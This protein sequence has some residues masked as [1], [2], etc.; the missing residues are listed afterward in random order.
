MHYSPLSYL[1]SFFVKQPS[2]E[3]SPSAPPKTD[4][5]FKYFKDLVELIPQKILI[6]SI[7]EQ[8]IGKTT[9]LNKLFK[10][11]FG[12][13]EMT[14][15]IGS[16]IKY[17]DKI[18][19]ENKI[20]I[21]FKGFDNAEI[22]HKIENIIFSLSFAICDV[23]F[24]HIPHQKLDSKY[25]ERFSYKYWLT[26]MSLKILQKAPPKIILF[27]RDPMIN[28]HLE[29]LEIDENMNESVIKFQRLVNENLKAI[30]ERYSVFLNI[31]GNSPSIQKIKDHLIYQDFEIIKF[32]P[33]YFN[34]LDQEYC[35]RE[36]KTF[37]KFKYEQILEYLKQIFDNVASEKN[38][39]E[40]QNQ[41]DLVSSKNDIEEYFKPVIANSIFENWIKEFS[42]RNKKKPKFYYYCQ[43][44]ERNYQYSFTNFDELVINLE[45]LVQIY[46][47]FHQEGLNAK[48]VLYSNPKSIES[49]KTNHERIYNEVFDSIR[50]INLKTTLSNILNKDSNLNYN[51]TFG[52]IN[53][54]Q[55]KIS[56]KI[57]IFTIPES[58]YEI[59]LS[60]LIVKSIIIIV[61]SDIYDFSILID[62]ITN[63]KNTFQRLKSI[64]TYL[65]F[66][67]TESLF[68]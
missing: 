28:N 52:I 16:E 58:L 45:L 12:G 14:D 31:T 50:S 6:G 62:V 64:N 65:D 44:I 3:N 43:Y 68:L 33:I 61:T 54:N 32:F 46:N 38:I 20:F 48:K 1:K 15:K 27:I 23:I 47:R 56:R 13:V 19:E 60:S 66:D 59:N 17:F 35:T 29:D 2:I 63:A 42:R 8:S 49:F 41:T 37:E 9:L 7:G 25:I 53:S 11:N 36:D 22:G 5:T 39:G 18:E 30:S 40:T 21:D 26:L 67:V 10:I 24:L 34:S 57:S 51:L 4:I 55:P